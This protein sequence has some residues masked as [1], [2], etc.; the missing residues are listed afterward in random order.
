MFCAKPGALGKTYSM[1]QRDRPADDGSLR[2]SDEPPLRA[3][4]SQV[5]YSDL[6]GT[7]P[8]MSTGLEVYF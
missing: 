1:G 4:C 7:L 3:R 2:H 8:L 5:F 6:F